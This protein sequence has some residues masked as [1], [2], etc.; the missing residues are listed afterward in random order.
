MKKKFLSPKLP[1]ITSIIPCLDETLVTLIQ[2]LLISN[3]CYLVISSPHRQNTT[4]SIQDG[5]DNHGDFKGELDGNIYP[6]YNLYSF[7]IK[8]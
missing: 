5:W 8:S 6:A 3:I 1:K 2:W 4:E 7:T